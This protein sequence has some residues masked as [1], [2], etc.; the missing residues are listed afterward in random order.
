MKIFINAGHGGSDP[1]ACGN[2]LREADITFD[3][4]R[5]VEGYLQAVGY[6]AK[7]FQ[8][9]GVDGDLEQICNESNAWGADIFVSIHCNAGGGTGK[10][11][12]VSLEPGTRYKLP[13]CKFTPPEGKAFAGWLIGKPRESAQP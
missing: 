10:M 2:G 3:I 1:G 5:H 9:G 8:L 12:P 11:E 4:A 13:E 7:V 6:D